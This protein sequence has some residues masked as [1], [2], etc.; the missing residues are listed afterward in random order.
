MQ[1]VGHLQQWGGTRLVTLADGPERGVRV[2]EFRTTSGLEFAVL[3]DR[4]FDLAWARFQGRSIAWHSPTGFLSPGLAEIDPGLGW[5]RTFGGGLLVTCGLDHIFDPETDSEDDYREAGRRGGTAYGL[6]GRASALP[7]R[8]ISYGEEW[9]DGVCHLFAEGEMYQATALAENIRLVRRVET[10]LDGRFVRWTDRVENA[11]HLPTSHMLLYHINFGAPL[12]SE[13]TEVHLPTSGVTWTTPSVRADE[14]ESF[15]VFAPPA[16]GFA[17]Q[18]FEHRMR[19]RADNRVEAAIVN[20]S[21]AGRPWGVVLD[22]DSERFPHF[23]QWRYLAS[24]NYVT[25]F[26]PSTNSARGRAA[27]RADGELT[28]LEPGETRSSTTTLT[29]VDGVEECSAATARIEGN[30]DPQRGV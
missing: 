25:A 26:E 8:L 21:D 10:T 6:H 20:R 4:C 28:L 29:I 30:S 9:R 23:F 17:Q 15:R 13:Q 12:L 1:K 3:V 2:V 14:Q 27:A 18:T 11:W 5:L 7:G 19:P 22:Y 16:H 24:G